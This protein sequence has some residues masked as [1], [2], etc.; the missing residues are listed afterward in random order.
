MVTPYFCFTAAAGKLSKVHMP[1]SA[2]A[3]ELAQASRVAKRIFKRMVRPS[4]GGGSGFAAGDGSTPVLG[5][6]RYSI[7]LLSPVW[8]H[9]SPQK[10]LSARSDLAKWIVISPHLSSLLD[11]SADPRYR[12]PPS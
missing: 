7:V 11:F 2:S 8:R 3:D 10:K 5:E 12:A 6:E 9:R 1:S 4:F